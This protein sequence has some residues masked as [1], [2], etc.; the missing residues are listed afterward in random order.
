[1]R[2]RISEKAVFQAMD[3]KIVV[4]NRENG[5]TLVVNHTGW[6]VLSL[7]D[8]GVEEEEEIVKRVA[9]EYGLRA[10]DVERDVKEFLKALKEVGVICGF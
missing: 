2:Y 5:H 6:F 1:M 9:E 10:E 8:G 3:D 7:I 4:W